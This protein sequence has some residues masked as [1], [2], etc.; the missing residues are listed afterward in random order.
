MRHIDVQY[1]FV[2]DM[3]ESKKVLLQKVDT[4]DNVVDSLTKSMSIEK[5]SWCRVEMV[6]YAL[7]CWS[8]KVFFLPVCK[9]KN[10]WDNIWYVL[11]S[12]HGA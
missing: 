7:D 1:H 2:R 8:R 5:F 3:A 12:L 4:L 9:E 6:I 10:E 11:Y